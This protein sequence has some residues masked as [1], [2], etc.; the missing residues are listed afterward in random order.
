MKNM[1]TLLWIPLA[2]ALTALAAP[3]LAASNADCLACH[4]EKTLTMER[5]GKSVPLYADK[6]LLAASPHVDLSC[7][8]CHEGFDAGNMPHAKK[9]QPVDCTTCH[10]DAGER[11][12]FHSMTAPASV[13]GKPGVAGSC[14]TCH[15]EHDILA[16][17]VADPL[18]RAKRLED[19]CGKC[20]DDVV[21]K[22]AQSEHGR[23]MA[24]GVKG[25][26]NCV[27]CHSRPIAP[28]AGGADLA[29]RKLAQEQL[30]LSCHRD[31]PEV[32]A[33]MGPRGGFIAAYEGSV[34]G[35]ALAGGK[36][37]AA[38]CVDCHGSH[39]MAKGMNPAS[40]ASKAHIPETC[41]QCHLKIA[42]E[43]EASVHGVAAGRGTAEAPVCTDCH[44]EH[45][46]LKTTD[47]NSPV[48][49]ANVSAQVC[50][51]CHSS[52]KLSQK[53]GLAPNRAASFA[54]SYHGLAVR[55]GSVEAAN[56]AS[57]HSA[58]NIR[59]SSDPLSTVNKANLTKTCGQCHPGAS[60]RFAM[61]SVHVTLAEKES[62]LL[63][64]IASMYTGMILVTIGG[65]FAHNALDWLWKTLGRIRGETGHHDWAAEPGSEGMYLRMTAPERLQ[66]ATLALSFILLT[67]TGFMLHYPDSWWVHLIR[68]L[69]DH[70][71]AMRGLLHRIAGVAMIL[72]SFYHIGYVAFTVRGRR[73]IRDIFPQRQ[74][75]F[76]VIGQVGWMVGLTKRKP[77]FGRFSY[78]EKSE[79]WALVWG[80]VVM[81]GTGAIL[82]FE[83]TSMGLLTKL[84][85]DIA[86]TVHFYEA[87]LAVL[88]IVVWHLYFVIFNPDVYPMSAAWATGYLTEEQMVEEHPLEMEEIRRQ[89]REAEL[90]EIAAARAA[91]T[92]G[93]QAP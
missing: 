23:A 62:P 36:G 66:H 75:M 81:G 16:L 39:E 30:C 53:Y 72:A 1:R 9:I 55:S 90:R 47:P 27:S 80:T 71:F 41:A 52:V 91:A 64:W 7:T 26:P 6:S 18:Q 63:Y 22:F 44:G 84:G 46:I 4:G 38:N 67:L 35:K 48:A 57:C 40:R 37:E 12:P 87:V 54:D 20:H 58:H 15:G 8:D 77:R 79:Y 13:S 65:M 33:R 29:K 21:K 49:P 60:N 24:E 45:N 85:W 32:R 10:A 78:I 76:D 88:A 34:H 83:N 31:D 82:W 17:K 43:Y 2:A 42:K 5:K 50:S 51:P 89:R 74:D 70:V 73:F 69:S 11:H 61:G 68:R 19:T 28:A 3:A 93:P 92:R 59:P 14:K 56:C 25:A 86:R